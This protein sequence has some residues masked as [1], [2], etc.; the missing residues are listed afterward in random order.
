MGTKPTS[1]WQKIGVNSLY[2]LR[3]STRCRSQAGVFEATRSMAAAIGARRR[4]EPH[5]LPGFLLGG[6][7]S[8]AI[9]MGPLNPHL[10]IDPCGFATVSLDE[11]GKR[12]RQ[13]TE[14]YKGWKTKPWFSIIPTA[15]G[16]APIAIST[17]PQLLRRDSRY[18]TPT[19]RGPWKGTRRSELRAALFTRRLAGSSVQCPPRA[20]WVFGLTQDGPFTFSN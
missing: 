20:V 18:P 7:C 10:T 11:H 6:Q 1:G 13:K 5:G 2:N 9:G 8:R 19:I 16:I 12:R 4:P 17:S 14:D 15:L 3:A